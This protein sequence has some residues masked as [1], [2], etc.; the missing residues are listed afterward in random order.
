LSA[1]AVPTKFAKV[2][3][4]VVGYSCWLD[5][6]LIASPCCS[7]GVVPVSWAQLT[8]GLSLPQSTT[9]HARPTYIS[10]R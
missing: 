7:D 5:I 10:S 1:V 4:R 9:V 3:P 8:T 2:T 6:T